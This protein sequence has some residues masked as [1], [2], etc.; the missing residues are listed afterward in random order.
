MQQGIALKWLKQA[1]ADLES[2]K[3]LLDS[4]K[5][6]SS[7]FYSQQAAEKC[8]KA[9]LIS[10]GDGLAHSHDLVFLAE[11]A[12]AEQKLLGEIA[13]L[14]PLYVRTRYPD[15]EESIPAEAITQAKANA[16][17]ATASKVIE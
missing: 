16:A 9:I 14:S 13:V 3:C 6:D 1:R 17:F 12:G 8:L 7:S 15:F 10:K 11:R 5:F 2:A 4:K